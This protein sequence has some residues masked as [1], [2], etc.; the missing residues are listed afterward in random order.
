MDK[1]RL[2]A[3]LLAGTMM[4]TLS[5]CGGQNL[6][7]Q[8][9]QASCSRRC[10]A[11]SYVNAAFLHSFCHRTD[12]CGQKYAA[13]KRHHLSGFRQQLKHK[14][15]SCS[16]SQSDQRSFQQDICQLFSVFCF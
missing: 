6:S 7:V 12:Q 2:G 9:K 10:H 16:G 11:A 15:E 13:K 1:R 4:V 5:G 14:P 3:W 8:K